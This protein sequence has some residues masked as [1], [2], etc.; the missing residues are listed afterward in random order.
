MRRVF[1]RWPAWRRPQKAAVVVL[2]VASGLMILDIWLC[3]NRS[4]EGLLAW[5]VSVAGLVVSLFLITK[6]ARPD[7]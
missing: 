4:W 6:A 1:H 3:S 5:V 2:L 7:A